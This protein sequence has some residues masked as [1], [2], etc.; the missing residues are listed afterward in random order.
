MLYLKRYLQSDLI[1]EDNENS[2]GFRGTLL[3]QNGDGKGIKIFDFRKEELMLIYS[4]YDDYEKK[5]RTYEY[6][7]KYYTIPRILIQNKD[8]LA[9]TEEYI[10]FELNKDWTDREYD[11]ILKDIFQKSLV[12]FRSQ[13]GKNDLIRISPIS[14]ISKLALKSY[15]SEQ[16]INNI[17]K[18]FIDQEL[19][20]IKLHGDLWT[21]NIL[22]S[23]GNNK[24]IFYIDWERSDVFIFYY[25]LFNFMWNEFF[26]NRYS[27]YFERYLSGEYDDYFEQMF[28]IFNLTFHKDQRV[29]YIHI[30]FLNHFYKRWRKL[31]RNSET[32]IYQVYQELLNL[33]D[34]GN[35]HYR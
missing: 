1:I 28:R 2:D 32:R 14:L 4:N 35:K 26:N 20:A 13:S 3:L 7:R 25:D 18:E 30:F 29:T 34:R 6:F 12:Y 31:N 19:P 9:V 21:S 22:I 27:S 15:L 11:L 10:N 17:G 24:K 23:Q 33:I 16:I 5:I 8:E